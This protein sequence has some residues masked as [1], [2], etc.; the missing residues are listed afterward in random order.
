VSKEVS[1][2]ILQGRSFSVLGT[3]DAAEVW[4]AD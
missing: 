3:M 1:A 2:A 4:R